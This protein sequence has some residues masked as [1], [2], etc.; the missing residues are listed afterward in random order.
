MDREFSEA[1]IEEFINQDAEGTM[2][3]VLKLLRLRDKA[4]F[5]IA[6]WAAQFGNLPEDFTLRGLMCSEGYTA[7]YEAVRAGHRLPDNLSRWGLLDCRGLTLAAGAECGGTLPLAADLQDWSLNNNNE[8][9]MPHYHGYVSHLPECWQD[10][11][12]TDNEGWTHSCKC[13]ERHL[14]ENFSLADLGDIKEAEACQSD[15]KIG[16]LPKV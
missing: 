3:K 2:P 5:T 10:M 6:H 9:W 14:P 8:S 16:C 4:G 12:L 15:D 7:A 11:I 13:C 1:E